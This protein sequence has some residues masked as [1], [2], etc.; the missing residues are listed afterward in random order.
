MLEALNINTVAAPLFDL[1]LV[2]GSKDISE[3][4]RPVPAP[5][6]VATIITRDGVYEY[7]EGKIYELPDETYIAIPKAGKNS[8]HYELASVFPKDNAALVKA[9]KEAGKDKW[10]A[11]DRGAVGEDWGQPVANKKD[12]EWLKERIEAEDREI[13]ARLKAAGYDFC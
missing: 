13:N 4:I 5:K 6:C 12:V 3:V 8:Y 1:R 11:L 2:L 7:I 9:Q 10:V